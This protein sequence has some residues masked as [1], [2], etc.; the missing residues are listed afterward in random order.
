MLVL[1][2]T[3][4][5]YTMLSYSVYWCYISSSVVLFRILVLY[6]K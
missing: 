5:T 2:F 6:F 4:Y 3:T 1:I